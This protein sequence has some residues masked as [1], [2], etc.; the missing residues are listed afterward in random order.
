VLVFALPG[1]PV[2]S[3]VCFELFARPSIDKLAGRGFMRSS[4]IQAR[5]GHAF[6]HAG[7]REAYLP[8]AVT[9]ACADQ[10]S[11]K[12]GSVGR[13]PHDEAHVNLLPWQGSAD[14]VTLTRANA[15]ARFSHEKQELEPG[16]AIEV[17]LI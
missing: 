5:L 6:S 16:A 13:R 9:Y 12:S 3:L 10:P 11:P 2:S 15:L 7:G 1:N 14:I 8:A 17:L 4:S